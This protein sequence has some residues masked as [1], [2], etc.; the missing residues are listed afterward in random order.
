MCGWLIWRANPLLFYSCASHRLVSVQL[1]LLSP[2]FLSCCCAKHLPLRQNPRLPCSYTTIGRALLLCPISWTH[3]SCLHWFVP[4]GSGPPTRSSVET[5]THHTQPPCSPARAPW[6][7]QDVYKHLQEAAASI[8][9]CQEN[10]TEGLRTLTLVE[11]DTNISMGRRDIK[12]FNI[13]Y[14]RHSNWF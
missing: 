11:K 8:S 7:I 14:Y 12:G 13:W 5:I 6:P 4:G 1:V 3:E 10:P 2:A 9:A